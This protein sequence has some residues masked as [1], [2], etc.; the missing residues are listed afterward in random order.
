MAGGIWSAGLNVETIDQVHMRHKI[1]IVNTGPAAA[2]GNPVN[3]IDQSSFASSPP[4]IAAANFIPRFGGFDGGPHFVMSPRTPD[5]DPTLGFGFSLFGT[6]LIAPAQLV[7]AAAGGYTVTPWVLLDSN[8]GYN[9]LIVSTWT[10]MAPVTGMAL[11][12]LFSSFDI[13]SGA[14]RFQ[15]TNIAPLGAVDTSIGIAFVE[16]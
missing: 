14:I 3:P 2:G 6:P 8:Q 11:N 5:G 16:L 10:A 12:Q 7:P 4:P 9:G 1:L 15:I 13:N